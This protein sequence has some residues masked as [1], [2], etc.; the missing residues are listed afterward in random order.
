M[1]SDC[2]IASLRAQESALERTKAQSTRRLLT[3]GQAD[4]SLFLSQWPYP[5]LAISSFL[6][7]D[8]NAALVRVKGSL[9]S[10][11][12]Q[13]EKE[14]L[15]LLFSSLSADQNVRQ[16]SK[17]REETS[18][19]MVDFPHVT[20][21][22]SCGEVKGSCIA[23][24]VLCLQLATEGFETSLQSEYT[25]R[26]SPPNSPLSSGVDAP[27][28]LNARLSLYVH[29]VKLFAGAPTSKDLTALLILSP[30]ETYAT[31]F[32]NALMSDPMRNTTAVD[33]NSLFLDLSVVSSGVEAHLDNPVSLATLKWMSSFKSTL[34]DGTA[35][36]SQPGATSFAAKLPRGLVAHIACEKLLVSLMSPDINPN[37]TGEAFIGLDL[38]TGISV[39]YAA[40]RPDQASSF[41]HAPTRALTR[42]QLYLEEER[43]TEALASAKSSLRS[44]IESAHCRLN[45][46][47]LLLKPT[48]RT[49]LGQPPKT[50]EHLLSL[51]TLPIDFVLSGSFGTAPNQTLAVRTHTP[52][53]DLNLS[54]WHV[55]CVLHAIRHLY[56]PGESSS[57]SKPSLAI[58]M[59]LQVEKVSLAVNLPQE[60]CVL[61]FEG[62]SA[63][64]QP[65]GL[66]QGR[67]TH[68]TGY[69]PARSRMRWDARQHQTQ[70]HCLLFGRDWRLE[71]QPL[72]DIT[73]KGEAI[74]LTV[75][76]EYVLSD[77]VRDIS[78]VAKASKHLASN[79][80]RGVYKPFDSPEAEGPKSVPNLHIIF[81]ALCFEVADDPFESQL[82]LIW[83]ASLDGA[84][85]RAERDSAFQ[86]KVAT[87]RGSDDQ[88]SPGPVNIEYHF[89]SA[90]TVSIADAQERLYR[91]HYLDHT[92]RLSSF[93]QARKKEE[94]DLDR[95]I[96]GHR[97][98]PKPPSHL[99]LK[100]TP[101]SPPL[102]RVIIRG[103]DIRLSP[104]SFPL[105]QLPDFLHRQGG[106]MPLDSEYSL[107]IPLHLVLKFAS[108]RVTIRDYPYPLL[109]VP[110]NQHD[111]ISANFDSDIVIAE[112]MGS[113]S[114]V[115]WVAC[116]IVDDST[117]LSLLSLAV[118]KTI[119]PVKTFAAPSVEFT[120]E[121]V[122]HI[123]WSISY[124]SAMQDVTR[125]I[126]TFTSPPRDA[127][128]PIGFWDKVRW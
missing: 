4:I 90:H 118:P 78:V 16:P 58:Q 14:D 83:R 86:A 66:L 92:Q 72:R 48:V 46:F 108:L 93:L 101:P 44:K 99:D 37:S 30:T 21:D 39:Q 85:H 98:K 51:R 124:S 112:Q 97:R 17:T 94:E 27:F 113:A 109:D 56:R 71:K 117:G 2:F 20:V 74:R 87:I 102:L 110:P 75:P 76:S 50:L 54:I 89:G 60:N 79:I 25:A 63:N 3:L 128:P 70:W 19:K 38:S 121:S 8:P 91:L 120:T 122:V 95:E 49:E 5:W 28:Q 13:V 34:S 115:D 106:G 18:T 35:A 123:S 61:R 10:L 126:D 33:L 36:P 105:E 43:L 104:P 7:G 26:F 64:V 125:V 80:L 47:N 77:I 42:H 88:Q 107:L 119:M 62:I 116:P 57:P 127:S 81:A 67:L 69:V 73:L 65:G 23:D 103:L 9:D 53:I 22:I 68:I 24:E 41:K 1:D 59:D 45:S 6:D 32:A 52:S 55:H 29:P 15:E 111:Q 100:R 31:G 40:I 96:Y 82:G 84:K 11:D 12:F 114:S